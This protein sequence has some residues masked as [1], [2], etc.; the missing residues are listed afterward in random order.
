[1]ALAKPGLPG[2]ILRISKR[3]PMSERIYAKA[4]TVDAPIA[5]LPEVSYGT[6]VTSSYDLLDGADV[7][8]EPDT[9]PAELLDELF[10]PKPEAPKAEGN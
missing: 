5:S 1:M 10:A 7:I 2:K 8:E 3:A 9:I 6:W 4:P